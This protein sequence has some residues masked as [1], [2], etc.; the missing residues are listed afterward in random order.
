MQ[1]ITD[2]LGFSDMLPVDDLPYHLHRERRD[3][4]GNL[5]RGADLP[6]AGD[7]SASTDLL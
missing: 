3:L 7:L 1:Y 5:F 2:M 4:C 6:G